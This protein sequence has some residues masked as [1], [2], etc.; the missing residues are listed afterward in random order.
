V[1]HLPPTRWARV[2][3]LVAATLMLVK[4]VLQTIRH[5]GRRRGLPDLVLSAR[6]EMAE[7]IAW[8]PPQGTRIVL[9]TIALHAQTLTGAERAAAGISGDGAHPFEIWAQVGLK[10]GEDPRT[11]LPV[12]APAGTNLLAVPIRFRGHVVG[13]LCLGDKH[14]GGD[15][16]FEDQHM[17]EML[18]ARA[19]SALETARMHAAEARPHGWLQSVVDQMPEGILVVDSQGRVTVQNRQLQSFMDVPA[20][21]GDRFVASLG[22]DLRLPSGERLPPDELPIVRALV[23]REVT[24]GRELLARHADERLVPLLVSAAPVLMNDGSVAGAVLLCQDIST[25]RELHRLREEWASLVA[26]DLRQ[27]ISVIALRCS[28]LLRGPLS[29][30]QRDCVEQIA[31]SVHVLGRMVS[32]LMDASL[33]ESDRLRVTLD[34]LDLCQ[35]IRDVVR[36]TAAATRT[37]VDIRTDSRLFVKG[38]AQRLEQVITNLLSNAVKYAAPDTEIVVDLGVDTG[39]AHLRVT[40]V[41]DG[42]PEDELPFIFNRFVRAHGA[43]ARG[44]KG[45]GLGLYIAKGLVAAHRGRIWAESTPGEHTTFHV[46]LPPDDPPRLAAPLVHSAPSFA[47]EPV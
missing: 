24:V 31:R 43:D 3:G 28:L 21:G 16:T 32:D 11:S 41:G 46:T 2:A 34:R 1:T 6:T 37:R 42:I 27:P 4:A 40:N 33:L 47:R 35:L 26:H 15:F 9:Q 20:P 38:D 5:S 10:P 13:F 23:D 17:A 18:A 12:P 25:I 36:R 7:A 44:I 19:S 45:L 39:Q 8:L 14:G 30:E 22:I 29:G